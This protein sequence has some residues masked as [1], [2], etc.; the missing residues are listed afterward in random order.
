MQQKRCSSRPRVGWLTRHENSASAFG[1]PRPLTCTG[2]DPAPGARAPSPTAWPAH[3]LRPACEADLKSATT[4]RAKEFSDFS[5][6]EAELMESIGTLSRAIT[7]IEREMRKN[8]A[9][10]DVG[11]RVS[12]T[13]PSAEVGRKYVQWAKPRTAVLT[14]K[15]SQKPILSLALPLGIC[16]LVSTALPLLEHETNAATCDT[17]N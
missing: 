15:T 11:I 4:I 5:A 7:M 1:A 14:Y 6:S 2:R 3:L 9:A 10:A 12:M 13:S 8:P 17:V 16:E